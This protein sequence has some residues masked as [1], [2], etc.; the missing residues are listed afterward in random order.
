M[1]MYLDEYKYVG[2]E[3]HTG[4]RNISGMVIIGQSLL[5]L[6]IHYPADH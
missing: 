4:M 5:L 1:L 3:T 6:Y 2:G